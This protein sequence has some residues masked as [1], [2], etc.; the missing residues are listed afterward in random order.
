MKE[1]KAYIRPVKLDEIL[2]R[3]EEGGARDITVIRVHAIGELADPEANRR[4]IVR[5]H[6]E[7]YS[8]VVKLEMVCRDEEAEPL[9]EIIR[10]HGRTGARGD[11]RIFVSPIEEAVSIRTGTR[12]DEAL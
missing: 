12:G 7:K 11:G 9:V 3:L 4:R 5:S 6:R 2:E 1:I 10:D 8:A